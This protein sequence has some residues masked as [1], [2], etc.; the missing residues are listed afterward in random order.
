MGSEMCIRDRIIG[1]LQANQIRIAQEGNQTIVTGLNGTTINGSTADF[2]SERQ[3]RNSWI[4]MGEG[5]DS[6]LVENL[7]LERDFK[8]FGDRGNDDLK[9][10]SVSARLIHAEGDFGDDVLSFEDS[11]SSENTAIFLGRGDDTFAARDQRVGRNL[12]LFGGDGDDNFGSKNLVV[13]NKLV[14]DLG[15]G[16]DAAAL[17]GSTSVAEHAFV[18]LGRGNDA[19]SVQPEIGN[20]Q[21]DFQNYLQ[22]I[23]LSGNDAIELGR[24]TILHSRLRLDGGSGFDTTNTENASFEGRTKFKRFEAS[25]TGQDDIHVN[26]VMSRLESLGIELCPEVDPPNPPINNSPEIEDINDQVVDE[27]TTLQVPVVAADDETPTGQ[28]VFELVEGPEDAVIDPATGVIT[29][30]PS[31]ADGP[32]AFPATVQVSDEA[33]ATAQT[34]F[35][36]QV[37]EVNQAPILDPI[38]DFD[39]EVGGDVSFA[40]TATDLD[41]PEN[42]LVFSLA[43]DVPVG[44]LIDGS[45]GE[46]QW[47]SISVEPGVF[48]FEVVVSD[49][50]GGTDSETFSITVAAVDL[51]DCPFHDSL[52]G[53]AAAENGGTVDG[54]GTV[55]AID[56]H[57]TLTE[58]D[59]FETTL[60]TTFVVPGDAQVLSFTYDDL[61]FDTSDDS[62]INDAFEVALVD[63][64]GL[65]LIHI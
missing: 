35:S 63:S 46:F 47:T 2:S 65:S 36:I 62:F 24:S 8:F 16:E 7:R 58:G 20:G 22:V 43:G 23:G 55:A 49:G 28:L 19:F 31:E 44:A 25:E 56:C 17:L 30:T 29:W 13:N 61:N 27:L 64:E 38:S 3:F 59:S 6:V 11:S 60:S 34:S 57:A 12:R 39:S 37:N 41:L 50:N 54:H 53:F 21:A 9:L 26:E 5:N 15:R 4:Q 45:T 33:G 51:E 40:A 10:V 42:E 18:N 52:A 48:P 1:D 14:F 32:G